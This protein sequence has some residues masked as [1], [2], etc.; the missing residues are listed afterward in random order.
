[1]FPV[2]LPDLSAKSKPRIILQWTRPALSNFNFLFHHIILIA[3][4]QTDKMASDPD[5]NPL[6]QCFRLPQLDI[7]LSEPEV[8]AHGEPLCHRRSRGKSRTGCDKC[9]E[10]R[11]K[12]CVQGF[13]N[14]LLSN[15]G[16]V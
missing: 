7:D 9:K 16:C 13:K 8:D 5:S 4:S 14:L 12:V 2:Q 15:Y 6:F 10:R 3:S 1:V 11:V